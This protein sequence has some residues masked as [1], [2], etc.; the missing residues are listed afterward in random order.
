MQ[1]SIITLEA[2]R[3]SKPELLSTRA[4]YQEELSGR[5]TT[6]AVLDVVPCATAFQA[7]CVEVAMWGLLA[8]KCKDY[9]RV[10]GGKFCMCEALRYAPTGWEK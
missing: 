8:G 10:R 2:P 9:N 1:Q 4:L 5:R 7:A 3:T 6:V